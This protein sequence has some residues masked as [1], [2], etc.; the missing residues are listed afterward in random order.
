VET[1][2]W[3]EKSGKDKKQQT[4]VV[5]AGKRAEAERRQDSRLYEKM[6]HDLDAEAELVE[7][8]GQRIKKAR[9][10][11]GLKQAAFAQKINEKQSLL[12]KIEREEV[13]PSEA[14]RRKIERSLN[15][16]L[17]E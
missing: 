7:D 10:K 9:E 5:G 6:E 2:T 12:R 4:A 17:S 3:R 15:I 16:S 1:E 8:Y 14:V 13:L 11:A